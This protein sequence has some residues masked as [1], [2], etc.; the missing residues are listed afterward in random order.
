MGPDYGVRVQIKA[1]Q[2][3]PF[4]ILED[5]ESKKYEVPAP[6]PLTFEADDSPLTTTDSTTSNANESSVTS[7]ASAENSVSGK[8]KG[9]SVVALNSSQTNAIV[10]NQSQI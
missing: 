10:I 6:D 8:S 3:H 9:S 1:L 4:V 5:S 7:T 2:G